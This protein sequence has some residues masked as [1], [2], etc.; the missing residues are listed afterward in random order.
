MFKKYKHIHFVGIG[1]IG[2]SGIAEVLINLGYR[3]SGSDVKRGETTRRLKR[4]GAKIYY[5]HKRYNIEGSHVVVVSSAVKETNPEVKEARKLGIAVVPRAEML[6][7]L[8]RLKYGVA[9]AGTHGKTST[10]SIIGHLLDY[11][12]FDPTVIIG[13]KVN[14]LRSNAR[15]GKGKFLVAEADE[16][17]G[18]FLKLAPTIGVITNID[19]EHMENYQSFNDLKRAFVEFA[20]KVPFYGAVVACASHPTVRK[21]IPYVTRPIITYG[22]RDADYTARKITQDGDKLKFEAVYAGELLGEVSLRMTGAHNALNALAAIAVGRHLD[23]PFSTI[24]SA[25]KGFKGV[26]RRFQVLSKVGPI[27]VD[28]YAH[29]PVEIKA[30][31]DAAKSGWP[32]RRIVSVVQPHRYSRLANL[33]DDFVTSVKDAD[34]VV[35]MDVYAAGERPRRNHTGERLWREM[36]KKYPKKMIAFAPTTQEVQSTLAPWCTKEDLILF[37]G[38]GSITMTAKICSKSLT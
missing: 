9:V 6:A 1:G 24:K 17:D 28:D 34:A 25:L 22:D 38:A 11:A 20:N 8:M 12:K 14:N 30:T 7:E 23:I 13:G 15:L 32:T 4:L 37:M 16:S 29:H 33:F 31:I 18:S 26:V 27:V 2:M 21:I 10:T 19:P 3:V 35:V 36:C 5:D